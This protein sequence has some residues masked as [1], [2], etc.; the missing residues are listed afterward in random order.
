MIE[1]VIETIM[2]DYLHVCV[3]IPGPFNGESPLDWSL[4][5]AV[6]WGDRHRPH[7]EG[8]AW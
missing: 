6:P 1:I 8:A 3:L 4:R 7:W 5:E 2:N